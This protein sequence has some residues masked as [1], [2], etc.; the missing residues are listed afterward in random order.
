MATCS[1]CKIPVNIGIPEI[2]IRTEN[3]TDINPFIVY[4]HF[5]EIMT[6]ICG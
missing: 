2:I 4:T 6:I 1:C 5:L 3:I